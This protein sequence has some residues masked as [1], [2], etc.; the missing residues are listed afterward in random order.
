M[1]TPEQTEDSVEPVVDDNE[2]QPTD[3]SSQPVHWVASEYIREDHSK[4]WFVWFG[5]VTLAFIAGAW[6]L[7]AWTF[8]ALIVVMAAALAV[9]TSRPPRDIGYTLSVDQ[10]L[11]I[12]ERLYHFSDFK[13]F[14]LIND[15]GQ[16]SIMLIP[17]KR[18]QPGVSVYFPDEVG[19][20]IVDILGARLPMEDM[21]LDVID[22]IVRKLHL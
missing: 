18:F 3:I 6:Y 5:I 21:K 22:I 4:M 14:G 10:G 16:H 17:I 13:A 15:Q 8:V 11:Y 9:Y 12:G 19:E 20:Q 1:Y 2:S 7:R